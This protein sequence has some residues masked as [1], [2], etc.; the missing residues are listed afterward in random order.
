MESSGEE[1]VKDVRVSWAYTDDYLGSTIL[2]AIQGIQWKI[3][4]AHTDDYLGSTILHDIQGIQWKIIQAPPSFEAFSEKA[5]FEIHM[6]PVSCPVSFKSKSKTNNGFYIFGT[7]FGYH[8]N[9]T[10]IFAEIA[11]DKE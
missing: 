7:G 8:Q 5:V 6:L 2:Q 1:G 4:Q 3:I 10:H 9:A 11:R